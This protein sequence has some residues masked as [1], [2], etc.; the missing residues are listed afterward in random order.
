MVTDSDI[1]EVDD[2]FLQRL[3]AEICRGPIGEAMMA[4]A[5]GER[6]VVIKQHPSKSGWVVSTEVTPAYREPVLAS[7]LQATHTFDLESGRCVTCN[8]T[9]LMVR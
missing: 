1:P 2:E 6:Q 5:K 8:P 3:L 9:G 7:C 4:V